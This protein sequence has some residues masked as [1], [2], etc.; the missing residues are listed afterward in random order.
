MREWL[1]NNLSQEANELIRKILKGSRRS[2]IEKPIGQLQPDPNK[3]LFVLFVGNTFNSSHPNAMLTARLGYC[4]AFEHIGIP[5]LISDIR[6]ADRVLE[7]FPKAFSMI[8]SADLIGV[9]IKIIKILKRIPNAVWVPPW[10]NR[11]NQFFKAHRLNHRN[12]TFGDAV[13]QKVIELEP[14]FVFTATVPSGLSFFE[15][16]TNLGLDVLSLPLACDTT[17]YKK[18]SNTNKYNGVKLAFVGGYWRSK[19]VQIDNYLRPWES[20][21]T[22]YGSTPWP[23]TGYKGR[24]P[25]S[26]E[27]FLYRSAIGCP[28]INEPTVSL[29]KGQINE[30]IFKVL[31]SGGCPVVDC[32]PAYRE[33]FEESELNIPSSLEEFN[34]N[35]NKILFD[36]DYNNTIREMGFKAVM[37][38]HTYIKRAELYLDKLK[39]VK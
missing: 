35:I 23:Y 9:E 13:N 39:I 32:V 22:I 11:S 14:N 29:M 28:V 19:G 36:P 12:W 15:K 37:E 26:D 31:G 20:L 16:W 33:L 27:P 30:R 38:K 5:Y 34:H 21:L 8:Y 17:I 24:L 1:Q 3:P 4:N 6:D 25:F 18:N 7:L 2:L 10:F